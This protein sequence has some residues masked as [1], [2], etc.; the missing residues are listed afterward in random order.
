MPYPNAYPP[1]DLHRRTC[2]GDAGNGE[3]AAIS[4]DR[5]DGFFVIFLI[6]KNENLNNK[7]ENWM[8]FI[9]DFTIEW[10]L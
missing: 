2:P 7:N 4:A 10:D 3:A 1:H 6:L 5:A 8:G 9:A